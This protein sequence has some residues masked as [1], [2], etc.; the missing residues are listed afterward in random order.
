LEGEQMQN[1]Y[2]MG[3]DVGTGGARVG[4]FDLTGNAVAMAER[5]FP[6]YTPCNGWAEQQPDDWWQA[7]CA[8]SRAAVEQSGLVPESIIGISVDATCCTVV[9]AN[10]DYTP[11]RPAIMWMDL[12]ASEQAERIAA[13]DDPALRYCGHGRL[14]AEWMPCKAL[15]LKENE[16]DCYRR[17]ARIVESV[18]WITHRMTG[19]ETLSLNNVSVR[20]FY[21]NSRGGWPVSLYEKAGLRDLF[22]KFPKD[23]LPMGAPVGGLMGEAARQM[24]LR[25]GITVA[26]GGADAHTGVIGLNV[27]QPGRMALITG[28]S[29]LHLGL[30]PGEIHAKGLLGSFADAIVPGMHLVECGQ[31][32]SGSVINWVKNLVASETDAGRYPD[33]QAV[34]AMLNSKAA[35]LPPGSEGLVMTDYFQGNRTPYTDA[36]VRAMIYG[37]GLRHGPEHIYR[38]AIEGVCYGTEQI[39]RLYDTLGYRPREMYISGGA[40]NSRLWMQ[41]HADVSNLPI[42]VPK[43][44][45]APCLGSAILGAVGAG[46]YGGIAEAA[47]NMVTFADR[48]DPDPAAHGE[49]AF[50]VE[51]YI[52]SYGLMKDWMHSITKRAVR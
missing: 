11:L 16:P 44:R 20:W 14:S 42:Y 22:E 19:A 9:A 29:H 52:E 50:Y 43:Q 46:V 23:V 4:I 34:Y 8:A 27:T 2:V 47:Q 5:S 15:W 18:D 28:T 31:I 17:A 24:G 21:D 1:T 30:A 13:L 10:E 40:S 12:R 37:L 35:K 48:I 45:E 36:N 49:Y 39:L 6:L 41:I 33:S 3:I 38:A 25:E 7:I 26:E 32:S 51:K